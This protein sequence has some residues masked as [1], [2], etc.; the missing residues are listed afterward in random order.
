M[1]KIICVGKL[2]ETYWR[3]AL[4]EYQ[5]RLSKYTKLQLI[6]VNDYAT[7]S[8]DVTQ[9]KEQY[10]IEK[11]I[12]PK[13][14]VITMEIEGK[15]EDSI[16]FSRF[17]EN[18]MMQYPNITFIIPLIFIA[19]GIKSKHI[20]A[21]ISPDAN[22]NIKLKNLFEFFFIIIPNIPPNVVPNVPEK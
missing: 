6:E 10:E 15:N 16:T 13:D 1:I 12:D 4:Q 22:D 11:Y 18:K 3:D 20:I 5:K 17:L 2:K 14:Y 9:K 21:I 19:S 8:I 7:D